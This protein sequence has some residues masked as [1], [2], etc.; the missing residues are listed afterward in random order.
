M[1]LNI[2]DNLKTIL[3]SLP[4]KVTLVAVSK[5]Y[6]IEAILEA[7][8]AGQRHFG[9]NKVQEM[10]VKHEDLPKDIQW[11][12]IGH[13][14]KNKV[15]YIVPFIH[16]I[17][18]VDSFDLL[19]EIEKRASNAGRIINCLLQVHI[20]KEESKFGMDEKELNEVLEKMHLMKHTHVKGLMGMA[21]NTDD[22][23][24]VKQEFIELKSLFDQ[25]SGKEIPNTSMETLS[26]GMSGDYQLAIECGSN[27]VRIGS[28]IF[29]KRK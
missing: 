14:Q 24:V 11:H 29:G 20:A 22:L 16:L 26:M 5:T 18:S 4:E 13:L 9:E 15:K 2:A 21:T 27:C 28:S 8:N 6:P 19:L 7:Y 12:L 17:H 10:I 1:G 3:H 23:Q 25:L